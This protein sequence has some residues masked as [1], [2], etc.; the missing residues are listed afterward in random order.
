MAKKKKLK[1]D[2][3]LVKDKVENPKK[4]YRPPKPQKVIRINEES[5]SEYGES[6]AHNE[7][8]PQNEVP[9]FI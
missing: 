4:Y 6:E 8:T 7:A 9:T 2:A 1:A 5:G 3:A